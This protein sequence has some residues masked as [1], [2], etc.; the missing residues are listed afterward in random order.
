[1][2]WGPSAWKSSALMIALQSPYIYKMKNSW[3]LNPSG[4]CL[5]LHATPYTIPYSERAFFGLSE[6][7]VLVNGTHKLASLDFRE[8]CWC[9]QTFYWMMQKIK[10]TYFGFWLCLIR[11]EMH[12]AIKQGFKKRSCFSFSIFF[13][14][15]Y[16]LV[17][18]QIGFGQKGDHLP[19]K[20]KYFSL[21]IAQM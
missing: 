5:T 15:W 16:Y 20:L 2:N 8:V 9:H 1:M 13:R 19:E 17:K 14:W 6:S 21:K 18:F 7:I 12:L 3:Y 11:H 4:F 10:R